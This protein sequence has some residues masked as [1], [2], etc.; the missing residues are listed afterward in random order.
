MTLPT[1]ARSDRPPRPR[2]SVRPGDSAG[3]GDRTRRDL[4]RAAGGWAG[5]L[6]AGPFAAPLAAQTAPALPPAGARF[7][8]GT[9]V[10]IARALAKAPYAAPRTDDLPGSLRN[11]SREQYNAIGTAPGRALWAEAGLRFTL[12]PLHRGS[13]FADRV[14][15]ALIED[16][17]VRPVAY[18]RTLFETGGFVLPEFQEDPGFSGFRLR[19]RFSG[20]ELSDF[21]LFQGASFF[22][23]LAAGQGFGVTARA[24]TLRPADARGEE[25]P[26]FRAFWIERPGPGEDR[27]VVHALIDSESASGALRLGLRP[28][29]ASI[30]DIEGTIFPR[31]GIDHLGLGGM[32]AS[33]LFGPHDRRG[34]D[35]ARAGA[36]AAGGLQIRNGAEE[37]IWRPVHNPD[38]LQISS[39]LDADPKGFGLMQRAR[40]YAAFEDDVQHWEWRP[41][42][43]L[44][45]LGTWGEGAVTLLEIPSDSEFNENILAYWRPKTALAAGAE[46]RFA[47]R[48][49]WCWEPPEHPPV[50]RVAGTRSGRGSGG[51]RRLFLVDFTGEAFAK[52]G[53]EVETTLTASP[54]TIARQVLYPYPERRTMR[55]AFELDPGSERACELRLALRREGRQITET[56]LYRWTP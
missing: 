34:S 53:P 20:A 27:L 49:F 15:L 32:Q 5:A 46:A 23:L 54:G 1:D 48:Q 36:Y 7:E 18:D 52:P 21:A 6:A 14:S 35:D 13:I 19:A 47:Y 2:A 3:A 38:T 24:L 39:F 25:F 44:E 10:E 26:R 33:Y 9:V 45:P 55:V 43:W 37:A 31:V 51:N 41:S 16:G 42:L 8:P 29:E 56:W 22:R 40:A 17:A 4:L 50:A 11:L 30:A 28:G 12:E